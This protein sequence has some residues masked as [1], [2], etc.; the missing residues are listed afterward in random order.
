MDII[1]DK[2]RGSLIGGAC[3]D[4]LGYEVEFSSI[5]EIHKT[6]GSRGITAYKLHGG[7]AL[8]SDDTQMTL[9]TA[10]GLLYG[11]SHG[12]DALENAVFEAYL[13]WLSTQHR[14]KPAKNVSWILSSKKLYAWRAPGNACLSS[15]SGG[16]MG[17]LD[18]PLNNSKG[19][20]GVMRVA[21]V[22]LR[23]APDVMSPEA[24]ADL[25]AKTAAITHSHPLGYI[26]AA[27]LALIVNALVYDENPCVSKAVDRGME[28]I[29]S[30]Y[31]GNEYLD[32]FVSLISKAVALSS[33]SDTDENNIKSLGEGWVAEETIAIAV[34]CA[35]R[36]KTDFDSAIIASVNHSGDS[37]STG[38]VTGN[39]VGALVGCVA[40]PDKWKNGL[41][42]K[43]IIL[44]IADD[45]ADKNAINQRY[46]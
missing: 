20:G 22:G 32:Y 1:Q 44:T 42:L 38:A 14:H 28:V 13:D 6:F 8:V 15:L 23:Y 27:L 37:D 3:G 45:L 12:Y 33:N 17:T 4:A 18:A 19:C 25:G 24:L 40:I 35:L 41:E 31:N 5:N 39:I 7:E 29:K 43:D 26:S 10:C 21:P 36:Y 9:F 11:E 34:Y 30:L 2:I 46:N 16:V